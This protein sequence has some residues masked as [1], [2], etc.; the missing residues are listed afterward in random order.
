M[1]TKGLMN[2]KQWISNDESLEKNI[3]RMKTLNRIIFASVAALTTVVGAL[4]GQIII[5]LIVGLVAGALVVRGISS[6]SR[7]V[8]LDAVDGVD[9]NEDTHARLFN[10]IDGLC[11][12][13]GDQRPSVR[14][15]E[16]SYPTAVVVVGPDGEG[17][18]A[19][20]EEFINQMDRVEVE[21]VMAHLLW[22]LRMGHPTL[23]AYLS[24]LTSVFSKCGL[25]AVAQRISEKALS[26]DSVMWADIS[27][28][29]ATR[30]PPALVSALEKC[31]AS[32]GSVSL[33]IA[34]SL[35]FALP[36]EAES[37]TAR[38]RKFSNVSVSRPLIA[39]RIA[40]L[41]EI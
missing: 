29:Q 21:A 3:N 5:F 40:I 41:K 20:S 7:R 11:V 28:C 1:S 19:V 31:A 35:C 10:V 15:V 13:S 33:G 39:E 32:Q 30:F 34:E 4:V 38:Q 24:S 12:V 17:I 2:Q 9:A 6:A 27:A 16:S 23:V 37:D 25:G 26:Q 18:I 22:R 8:L 14:L 36:S